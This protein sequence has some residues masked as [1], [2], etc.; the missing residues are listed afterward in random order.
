ME[1][2]SQYGC[3]HDLTINRLEEMAVFY[4]SRNDQKLTLTILRTLKSLIIDVVIKEKDSK[5]LFECSFKLAK[6]YVENGHKQDGYDLLIELRRQ[7]ISRDTRNS[8]NCGFKFE[9]SI[10]RTS[11]VFLATFE[12]VSLLTFRLG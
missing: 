5:R 10:N 2:K 11:F 7:I 1:T 12:E 6:I 9:Q 4:K 8:G 3:S